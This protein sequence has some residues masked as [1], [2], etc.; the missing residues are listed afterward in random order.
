MR[1]LRTLL[2]LALAQTA[3]GL[4]LAVVAVAAAHSTLATALLLCGGALALIGLTTALLLRHR[5]RTL[6]GPAPDRDEL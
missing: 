6:S 3:C 5:L 1:S 2:W 4:A